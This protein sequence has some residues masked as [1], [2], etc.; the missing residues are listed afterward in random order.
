MSVG[1]IKDIFKSLTKFWFFSPEA[2]FETID[3][4]KNIAEDQGP[5]TSLDV[6]RHYYKK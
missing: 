2:I 3:E 6:Y 1:D 5:T 4:A